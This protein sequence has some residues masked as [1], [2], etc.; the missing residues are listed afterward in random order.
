M[1]NKE[2]LSADQIS[3]R[4]RSAK[5]VQKDHEDRIEKII[6]RLDSL[7]KSF[8]EIDKRQSVLMHNLRRVMRKLG[9][10]VERPG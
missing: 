9:L 10:G 5:K 4:I 3:K 8:L 1:S 2:S 6:E 7:D